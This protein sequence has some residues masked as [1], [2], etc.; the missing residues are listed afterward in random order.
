VFMVKLWQY[1]RGYLDISIKGAMVEKFI[2]LATQQGI[3][4][5]DLRRINGAVKAKINVEDFRLLRPL[6]R[7]TQCRVKIVGRHGL[8]FVVL[9]LRQRKGLVVGAVLFCLALYFL[10]SFIWFVE[11][12]G[13]DKLEPGLLREAAASLGV[14]PGVL[15]FSIDI[16]AV[17]QELLIEYDEIAWVGINIRGTKATIEIIEKKL[18]PPQDSETGRPC[19]IV[20]GQDAVIT[21]IAVLEGMAVVQEGET[22]QRGQVLISGQASDGIT[23]VQLVRANGIVEGRVWREATGEAYLVRKYAQRTGR[24]AAQVVVKYG[25]DVA[26]TLGRRSIPFATFE[27]EQTS[28]KL[29][30]WRNSAASVEIIYIRYF[31]TK[32]V[33]ETVSPEKAVDLA[34]QKATTLLQDQ[35]SADATVIDRR[36]EVLASDDPGRIRVRAVIETQESIGIARELSG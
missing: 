35:L 13:T 29:S 28:K 17:K 19:D 3:F 14:R 8:P 21:R 4:P 7:K 16:P 24:S 26:V 30:V 20:A 22:V 23:G 6:A 25:K 27:S 33:E 12:T 9:R 31:E 15:R 34:R 36:Y 2:N 32:I 10:S 18:P 5:W 1:L 11:I